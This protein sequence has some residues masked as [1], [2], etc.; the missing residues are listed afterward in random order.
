MLNVKNVSFQYSE[1][2]PALQEVNLSLGKGE[3]AYLIGESGSGKTTLL[4][5]LQG[6]I[7]PSEGVVEV[8]GVPL[9]TI[10]NKQI[11]SYRQSIG[12]IFQEF[13]LMSHKTVQENIK[14]GIE[15]LGLKWTEV[16]EHDMLL[17]LEKMG[18]G[19][20]VSLNVE[21]L[22]YGEKQRVAIARALIRK[23]K[24]LLADEPTGN[25]DDENALNVLKLLTDLKDENTT[26]IIATHAVHLLD[27]LP[28]GRI[29]QMRR[30][31]LHEK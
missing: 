21:A 20:K 12:P 22:S 14:V 30:G 1:G 25:L 18:I 29:F 4:K 16:H 7:L 23:P 15:A 10:K 28:E 6:R 3:I 27:Q 31:T 26:V 17:L 9:T 19:S 11:L 24:L 2:K 13:R 8:A 5:I